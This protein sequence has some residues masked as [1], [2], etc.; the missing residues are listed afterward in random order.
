[1]DLKDNLLCQI[2]HCHMSNEQSEKKL[3]INESDIHPM[4]AWDPIRTKC[5]DKYNKDRDALP[6]ERKYFSCY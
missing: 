5:R 2:T 1:M 4:K 3:K 6:H